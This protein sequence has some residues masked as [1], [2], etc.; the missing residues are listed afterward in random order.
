[1]YV[2]LL[3]DAFLRR[4]ALRRHMW[5]WGLALTAALLISGSFI[6]VEYGAV[7]TAR[8]AQSV[9]AFRSRD[10]HAV[11]SDTER[12]V[13]QARQIESTIATLKNARPE[14][15]TLALLAITSTS[16]KKLDG[17]VHLKQLTTQMAAAT[18]APQNAPPIPGPPGKRPTTATTG[19]ESAPNDFLLEGSAD[20]A[21]AI[22][23]FIEAIRETGVFTRVDL[24]ATNEATGANAAARH[25]RVE[26]KF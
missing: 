19:N 20:D 9:T 5:R 12:L 25:F 3:P 14:D 24:T 11:K 23:A 21:A 13:L 10:L 26:C 17:K 8:K 6:G 16:S 7:V 22:S 18:S 4:L 2:N 1:M 15:R